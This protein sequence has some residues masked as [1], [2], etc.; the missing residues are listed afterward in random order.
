VAQGRARS[1]S[2]AA[3]HIHAVVALHL[4]SLA[5]RIVHEAAQRVASLCTNMRAA[6][7]YKLFVMLS[8]EPS[9]DFAGSLDI[10]WQ[11]AGCARLEPGLSL[12][13]R[14][15]GTARPMP[16]RFFYEHVVASAFWFGDSTIFV[17]LSDHDLDAEQ[18]AGALRVQARIFDDKRS[19]ASQPDVMV[20]NI[21]TVADATNMDHVLA[22]SPLDATSAESC[23]KRVLA[24]GLVVTDAA[25]R[26]ML[27]V[28]RTWIYDALLPRL[29][30]DSS[31]PLSEGLD[32][33]YC[34]FFD[35]Q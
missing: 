8:G 18:S 14:S 15:L 4:P 19:R 34:L 9:P 26:R 13:V 27:S 22:L 12:V 1:K 10:E 35:K 3:R 17:D 32:K 33:L 28:H 25:L 20:S 2:S 23:G 29:R 5:S 30:A 6:P 31:L 21:R 11:K 24:P 16:A 7:N